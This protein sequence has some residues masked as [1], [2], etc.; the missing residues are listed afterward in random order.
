MI[1][2]NDIKLKKEKKKGNIEVSKNVC[3]D[4]IGTYTGY[5]SLVKR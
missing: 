3:V 4:L 2:K 1:R 5:N